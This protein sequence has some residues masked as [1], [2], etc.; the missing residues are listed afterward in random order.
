[1]NPIAKMLIDMAHFYGFDLE[2][3]Q[4]ELYVS[5]LEQFP[6]DLVL[7]SGKEYVQNPKN[8]KFPIPPHSIMA[9]YLPQDADPKDIGRLTALR[10][11]DAV[12]KFGWPHPEEARDYIG[13]GGW[14]VVEGFGGWRWLCENLGLNIP[15]SVF[16]AQC[17]DALESGARVAVAPALPQI[18][19]TKGKPIVLIDEMSKC[20]FNKLLPNMGGN[21]AE[22]DKGD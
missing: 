15:E 20:D 22:S 17:R 18:Q 16:M 9:K 10:I 5:V 14:R 11:R 7:Q 12:G 8:N 1:M 2:K 13:E 21:N 4:L 6:K 3:R 19:Q